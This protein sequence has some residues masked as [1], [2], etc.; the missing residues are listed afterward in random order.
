MNDDDR[1]RLSL[2]DLR[3]SILPLR[4]VFWGAVLCVVD[5]RIRSEIGTI[6]LVSDFAGTALVLAGL[7][8]LSGIRVDAVYRRGMRFAAV[9]ALASLAGQLVDF[10]PASLQRSARPFVE[11]A[12]LLEVAAV[13]VFAR[14]MVRLARS[15]EL[16]DVAADW[17][18][19]FKWF[20]GCFVAPL[21]LLRAAGM[22]WLMAGSPRLPLPP[23][24]VAFWLAAILGF[25]AMLLIPWIRLFMSTSRLRDGLRLKS[26]SRSV[27]ERRGTRASPRPR[28][29]S[30]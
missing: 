20:L 16:P 4:L 27:R 26:W 28:P 13:A 1:S 25:F 12:G 10:A 29:S 5:F 30:S 6:D 21:G 7:W 2:A 17:A 11:L 22:L 3:R 18:R 15:A 9:A 19:T 14:M 8:M 24:P 23:F